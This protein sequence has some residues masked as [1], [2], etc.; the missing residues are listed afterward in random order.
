VVTCS[1][2][3]YISAEKLSEEK[4]KELLHSHI[5]GKNNCTITDIELMKVRS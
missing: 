3:G 4:A 2:C 1:K 5:G